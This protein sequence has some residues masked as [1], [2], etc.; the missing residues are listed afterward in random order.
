MPAEIVLQQSGN[1]A[2][3]AQML[4]ELAA[5]RVALASGE[6]A[7]AKVR[8][9]LKTFEDRYFR[10]VGVLYA[11]LDELEA[12]IAEREARLYDSETARSRAAEAR[13]QA[14]NSRDAAADHAE[15]VEMPDPSPSLKA[16]FR[17]VAKRIHPDVAQDNAEAEFFTLLMARANQAYRRG[18]AETLQRMLDD[19]RDPVGFAGV[20]GI[21]AETGRAVRQVQ[22]V[23]RDLAALESERYT[24][25]SS[26][27]AGL[28]RDAEAVAGEGRD[29]L[30]ELA[31]GL[32]PQIADARYR[33][34]FLERQMFAH[35][36]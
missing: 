19:H 11:E 6:T 29:L 5:L 22:H 8:A 12:G 9:K 36:R 13:E 10:E 33:L 23:R 25:L 16:L 31:A 18:D 1:K 30:L 7:L 20:D 24:L 17:D 28:Q 3:L 26:E 32:H 2:V 21:A 15:P 35:G 4:E 14:N 34:A 27:L